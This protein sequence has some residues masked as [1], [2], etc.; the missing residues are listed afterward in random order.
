[1]VLK[2][3]DMSWS[4]VHYDTSDQDLQLS[5][6]DVLTGKTIRPASLKTYTAVLVEFSLP[7]SVYATMALREVLKAGPKQ[8]SSSQGRAVPSRVK[9]H[10]AR[11]PDG[12]IDY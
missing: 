4:I 2:V 8:Y 7:P 11:T 1:M 6:V 5:D 3:Q 9:V 10:V 12:D